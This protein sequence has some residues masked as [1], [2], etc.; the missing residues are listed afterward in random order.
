MSGS[1]INFSSN[2][3]NNA[4]GNGQTPNVNGPFR[5]LGGINDTP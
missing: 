1:P 2:V 5:I 3:P 4:P